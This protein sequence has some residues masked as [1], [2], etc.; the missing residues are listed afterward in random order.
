MEDQFLLNL[1]TQQSKHAWIGCRPPANMKAMDIESCTNFRLSSHLHGQFDTV[2]LYEQEL[3]NYH[4]LSWKIIL[5]EAIRLLKENGKLIVHLH[6]SK[7]L[8]IPLLKFF[9]GRN[10]NIQVYLDYES[11]DSSIFVFDIKRINFADYSSP[12]WTFA[13]LTGGK[14]DDLVLK[15]LESIRKHDPQN[16]HEIIISGPKKDIYDKYKVRYLDLSKFRDNKYAEISRKKNAIA[17]MAQNPNLLIAH[18]RYYLDDNFFEDFA[19]YGYDWDFLACRQQWEDGA[20]FPFYCALYEPELTY[21]TS[22]NSH[23]YKHLLNTQYVNG[24]AMIFKTRTLQKIRFNPLLLWNQME[25]VEIT[26]S[27]IQNS[28]IPRVNWLSSLITIDDG[29]QRS[30]SFKMFDQYDGKGIQHK[31]RTI[32]GNTLFGVSIEQTKLFSI[33]IIKQFPFIVITTAPKQ[34][35]GL[36]RQIKILGIKITWHSNK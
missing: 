36:K 7:Y 8:T 24:G 10:L 9:L 26:K 16:R 20:E 21:T 11:K 6:E 29:G 23:E 13:M 31:I 19:K 17:D 15:F 25:D 35:K 1:A 4:I 28:V 5:D 33:D 12:L 32:E 18:D 34:K 14:K 30:A 3:Q 22:I 2:W 27:F